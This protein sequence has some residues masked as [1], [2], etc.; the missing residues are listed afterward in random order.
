MTASP[1]TD[2]A[3]GSGRRKAGLWFIVEGVVLILLG[4][5]AAALPALAGIAAGIV[6]GWVLVASGVMGLVSLV[7]S[8]G[9]AHPLWS[10]LSALIALVAGVLVLW[11][12]IAGVLSLALLIAFYLLL[13]AGAIFALALDQR[14]RTSRGWGWLI[15]SAVAGIVLAGFIIFLRPLADAVLIGFIVAIDLILG[16]ICLA[17]LG[18]AA[19]RAPG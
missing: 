14:R 9:S 11:R 16:G 4:V 7:A 18:L 19:R 10:A 17:A 8:R 5:L 13:D 6:F 15:L 12:P 2:T 3:A 1:F